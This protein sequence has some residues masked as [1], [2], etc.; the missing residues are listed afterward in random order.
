[1]ETYRLKSKLVENRKEYLIQTSNDVNMYTVSTHVFVDG[2]TANSAVYPHPEGISMEEVLSLVEH[3]HSRMKM[4]VQALLDARCRVIEKGDPQ[5]MVRVGAR[6][7]HCRFWLE[8]QE[9]FEMATKLDSRCHE[10]YNYLGMI[11]LALGKTRDA[12]NTFMTAVE[13]SPRY[14][15]YRNNL[16]E[17]LLADESCKRATIEFQEA[18]RINLYYGDAYFNLGLALL[19]NA[20]KRED[21]ELFQSVLSKTAD[22]FQ[23]AA[24]ICHEYKTNVF[25]QGLEAIR[26]SNLELAWKLLKEVRA[27]KKERH[28]REAAGIY[29]GVDVNDEDVSGETVADRIDFLLS[30][31][32]RNPSY[33]D[34]YTQLGTCYLDQAR[35][36][37]R[38]GIEQ[39]QQASRMNPNL[40]K[41]DKLLEEIDKT[42]EGLCSI[43]NEV[44]HKG[45]NEKG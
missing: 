27:E 24:L 10:A 12:V 34:L 41:I 29:I 31:I 7:F 18:V 19:L 44:A 30:E 36:S 40:T 37:W 11:E 13:I 1:M 8:A 6:F 22:C 21:T 16:G 3:R 32:H 33:V 43:V 26:D 39:Y 15:D 17:A 20:I 25:E 5:I 2:R 28:L 9:L 14:A 45:W 4:D 35:I 38:K 23:K 42:Y